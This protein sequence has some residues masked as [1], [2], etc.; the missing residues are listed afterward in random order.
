MLRR[1]VAAKFTPLRR[2]ASPCSQMRVDNS[3]VA[4][5]HLMAVRD[6]A[7]ADRPTQP[8]TAE[9]IAASAQE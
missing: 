5:A 9:S 1:S 2:R 4:A 6:S 7:A 8:C 3:V